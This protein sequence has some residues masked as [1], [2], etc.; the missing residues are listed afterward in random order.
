MDVVRR[1]DVFVN[2]VLNNK[3]FRLVFLGGGKDGRVVA[4]DECGTLCGKK[5]IRLMEVL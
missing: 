1:S 2:V 3:N 5:R 4:G